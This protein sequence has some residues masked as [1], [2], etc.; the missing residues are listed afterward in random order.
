MSGI[1]YTAASI[2]GTLLQCVMYGE[3]PVSVSWMLRS[4]C[5][6]RTCRAG[7]FVPLFIAACLVLWEKF[8]AGRGLNR[9]L[10]SATAFF[11][12]SVTAV[13]VKRP[14]KGL[15]Q[16]LTRWCGTIL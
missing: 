14:S 10:A 5:Q 3:D 15:T 8:S 6:R 2:L 12:L 16:S 1:S 13:S 11:G 7:I 9:F 4:L